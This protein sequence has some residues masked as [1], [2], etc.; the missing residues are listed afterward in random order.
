MSRAWWNVGVVATAVV[1]A[2]AMGAAGPA[3]AL[4][5]GRR[6]AGTPAR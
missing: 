5:F 4:D 6:I 3:A 1:G 2:L